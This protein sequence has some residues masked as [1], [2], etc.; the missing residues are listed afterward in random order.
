MA[1][2]GSSIPATQRKGEDRHNEN[3]EL[4]VST[5]PKEIG[6]RHRLVKTT[7][8]KMSRKAITLLQNVYMLEKEK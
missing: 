6:N 8:I 1:D 2:A 3:K 7:R 4:L 5:L